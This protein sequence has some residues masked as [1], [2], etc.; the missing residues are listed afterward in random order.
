M[1]I[2]PERIVD[3][4]QMQKT[5]TMRWRIVLR[6]EEVVF[7]KLKQRIRLIPSK[8]LNTYLTCKNPIR[9]S[10]KT[11]VSLKKI[12]SWY[13]FLSNMLTLCIQEWGHV[14]AWSILLPCLTTARV[15]ALITGW[16]DV[17]RLLYK[18]QLFMTLTHV[19]VPCSPDVMLECSWCSGVK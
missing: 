7:V 16:T 8:D 1:A 11:V 2:F 14:G 19:N 15:W 18:S 13:H 12:N 4:L 9:R 6:M 3:S 17:P 10:T 5:F